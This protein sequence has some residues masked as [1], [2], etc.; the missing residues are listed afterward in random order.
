M[1][2]TCKL[3]GKE[4]K[5]IGCSHVIPQWMNTL[6]V[7]KVR[8]F[9]STANA[10][11]PAWMHELSKPK[12][13]G[14]K[15]FS[16]VKNEY[17]QRSLTGIYGKFVCQCCENRFTR[18]D[19]HASEVL[20]R[21]PT[22]TANGWD[23]GEYS[24]GCL[25]RFYLS[26]L[27]RASACGHKYFETV[28]LGDRQ[29]TLAAAL[30]SKDDVALEDFDVLPTRCLQLLAFGVLVP[31]AVVVESVPHWQFYMPLFQ[32][33]IKVAKQSGAPCIQPHKL[34]PNSR[35]YL[36]DKDFTEFGELDTLKP[37]FMN[38]LKKKNERLR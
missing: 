20:R 21:T 17:E 14:Y 25:T 33:L 10:E 30:L 31:T 4:S 1:L 19:T 5:L 37:L 36:L 28:D 38:H 26:V 7:E 13:N 35:L 6:L 2:E 22:S 12:S 9:I 11:V 23:Y 15:I 18:W 8:A 34:R 3:C 16:S 27:W 24:Y 29:A 32:A